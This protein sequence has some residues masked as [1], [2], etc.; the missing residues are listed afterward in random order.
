MEIRTASI[1][2]FIKRRS[3]RLL[4]L[5]RGWQDWREASCATP[6][7]WP[8]IPQD[9]LISGA[10]FTLPDGS[11]NV[12]SVFAVERGNPANVVSATTFAVL[13]PNLIDALFN[14]G[15]ASAG[16]TF[17]VFASG[18]SGT[19][20]NLTSLPQGAAGCPA[21]FVGNQ[22][23]IQVTF[24]C[25]TSNV[26]PVDTSGVATVTGCQLNRTASGV[27]QLSVTGSNIRPRATVTVN[28]VS[29]KKV[30][31]KD[32]QPGTGT[33]NRLILKG[34]FCAGLSGAIVITNPGVNGGPSKPFFC[35]QK[36]Q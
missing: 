13:S 10:C 31:F 35:G 4:S 12:I 16:K 29:P 8:L 22:Q 36:C 21:G 15:T 3:I 32:K 30:K 20:Q 17:L 7:A 26:L 2:S 33:F 27:F 25:N 24:T 6:I 28:G 19:S 18:P 1:T 5:L 34:R 9:L 11:S 23:G 14:F